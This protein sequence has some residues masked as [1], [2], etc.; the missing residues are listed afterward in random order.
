M[1]IKGNIEEKFRQKDNWDL[2]VTSMSLLSEMRDKLSKSLTVCVDV[3][4]L[5][6]QFLNSL[7]Q[8]INI[9]N[10]KY[11]SKSCTLKFKVLDG[12]ESM[13][14]DL[15]SK[16]VKVSPSDELMEDIYNLTSLRAVLQ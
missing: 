1:H 7:E 15:S 6:S 14:V 16:L 8:A 11:P 3:R 12:E 13:T 2:R 9:N 4:Q 5:N 10:E